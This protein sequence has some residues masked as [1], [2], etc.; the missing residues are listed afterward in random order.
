MKIS[1]V[2]IWNWWIQKYKPKKI[3]R[4]KKIEEYIIDETQIKVGSELIWL[5]VVIE[6]KDR[7][8]LSVNIKRTKHVCYRTFS[9]RHVHEYGE[10]LVSTTDGGTWYPPQACQFL[11]LN[12]Y[13]HSSFDKSIIERTMQ[14]IKKIEQKKDLMIIF[15]KKNRCKLKHVKQWLNL[16]IDQ[17]NKEMIS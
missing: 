12:H 10:H 11:K 3:H 15:L 17:H 16:F 13:I 9:G 8:I 6:P 2:S 5:W 4:K 1:H 14:Y 7:E